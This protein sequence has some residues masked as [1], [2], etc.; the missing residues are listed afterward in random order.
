MQS[1]RGILWVKTSVVV[2]F[3]IMITANALANIVPINGV[4]TGQVSDAYQNL[5]TPAGFIF[6]IWGVIYLLVAG[7]VL[8]A[9]GLFQA[10]KES[11]KTELLYRTGI[12][13]SISSLV[14]TAWILCWHYDLI[15]LTM[16]LMVVLL[17]SLAYIA[18]IINKEDL[19]LRDKIF[20]RLPFSVYF[21]WISVATIA[22]VTVLLVRWN[23]D[24]FGISEAVWAA[25]IIS[26]GLII[27][28]VTA[29][30]N[31]DIVYALVFLW[32]YTGILI[33]HTSSSGFAGQHT[34]VIS[35]VII[36]II[37]L[38]LALVYIVWS[39]KKLEKKPN[40]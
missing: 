23:W 22:N 15:P 17:G 3:L 38:I 39:G 30:K 19:S 32:A 1:K 26:V 34:E 6:S 31:R 9:L 20:I 12:M 14:N 2:T 28:A 29:V 35:T 36:S 25:I 8:Y 4:S 27:G 10:D 33:K 21:G 11:V 37:L 40:S 13:F 18:H 16:L 24:G 7:Y 5:F